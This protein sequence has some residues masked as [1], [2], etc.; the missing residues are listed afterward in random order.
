MNRTPDTSADA[1]LRFEHALRFVEEGRFE[2]AVKSFHELQK[3]ATENE[4]KTDC[5]FREIA[6][7]MRLGRTQEARYLLAV[8]RDLFGD[9]TESHARGDL[10]EIQIDPVADKWDRVL[11]S[12]E[13]MLQTYAQLFAHPQVWGVYGEVQVRRGMRLAYRGRFRE[14]MPILEEALD[15]RSTLPTSDFYC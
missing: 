6:G 7:L 3:E 9:I 4:T 12:L 10:L 1:Q 13:Q 5:L 11:P 8:K 14:A 2:E 15:F